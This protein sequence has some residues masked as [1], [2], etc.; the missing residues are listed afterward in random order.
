MFDGVVGEETGSPCVRDVLKDHEEVLKAQAREVSLDGGKLPVLFMEPFEPL[1][2]LTESFLI[3]RYEQ[4]ACLFSGKL[5]MDLFSNRVSIVDQA[6]DPARGM[7]RFFDGEGVVRAQDELALIEK[8]RF[9]SLLCDLRFAKKFGRMS[10]GNG[11]RGY[12]GGVT[13]SPHS[14]RFRG[15]EKPWRE[16]VCGLDR[17]LVV[18]IAAGGDTN[19]LGEFS[20]PVQVGYVFEKGELTGRAP[21]LT[22]KTSVSRYL[23]ED[24]IDISSDGFLKSSPSPCVISEMDVI[25]N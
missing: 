15:G 5:G 20:T 4:G 3:N 18:M 1:A 11:L 6:Y 9:Q 25:L 10:T 24:L 7:N 13:L 12:K 16:I 19:D 23:K 2:K 21:Q 8:G 22:L 14:L 17:C